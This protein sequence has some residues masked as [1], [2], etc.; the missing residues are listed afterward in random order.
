MV[1][2]L[3]DQLFTAQ[4]LTTNY[5]KQNYT[6]MISRQR[7][8]YITGTKMIQFLHD[9]PT[10]STVKINTKKLDCKALI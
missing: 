8:P 3:P 5:S 10:F 4:D 6:N 2:M 1:G 9:I 7:Y